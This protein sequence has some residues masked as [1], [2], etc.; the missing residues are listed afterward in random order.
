MSVKNRDLGTEICYIFNGRDFI[1]N[2]NLPQGDYE[3]IMSRCE[4]NASQK[5][6]HK[7]IYSDKITG[8]VPEDPK[9]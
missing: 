4:E 5:A 1:I 7:D 9:L 6:G 2:K 3:A 8:P